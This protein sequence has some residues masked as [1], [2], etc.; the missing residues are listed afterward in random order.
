MASPN[1]SNSSETQSVEH[2]VPAFAPKSV[3]VVGVTNTPGT[4]PHDI[5]VNILE[6]GFK[7]SLYP[8]APGKKEIAGV[9]AYK[10]VT[11]IE[12]EVDLGIIVFPSHC[13]HMALEQCGQKGVKAVIIISAGFR[14][15]G[16][17]G[18]EREQKVKDI[19]KKYGISIIGPNCLGVINT[20]PDVSLNASF[21]RKMPDHGHIGF[22]SQSG[23]L[24][25]AVLDYAR[26]K[27]IGFSKFVSFGNK[28]GLTELDLMRY[29]SEDDDTRV[30]L[31]YLE[32]MQYGR[33]LIDLARYITKEA[34]NPKPILAIK[35]GRT[36][37]GAAAAASHTGSL[38]GADVVCDSIFKQ[39]GII[40][41][42][43]IED[44]FH[45]ATMFAYQ[46]LPKSN[47]IAIITN[48]GG[49][50]VMATDAIIDNHLE[51]AQF[52]PGTTEVLKES[53]PATAN[54]KNPVD[55][56]GDAREDRYA[57]ALNAV[58]KDPNVEQILTILTPQSMT[59]IEDIAQAICE[60]ADNNKKAKTLACSFMG[61]SDVNAGIQILVSHEIPHYALPEQAASSLSDAMAYKKWKD[62]PKPTVKSFEVDKKS[63]ADVIENAPEGYLTELQA[64]AVLKAYGLPILEPVLTHSAAEAA[65]ACN[66]L[67]YPIVMKIVSPDIIH[68]FDVGG[69]ILDLNNADEVHDAYESMLSGIK[70]KQPNAK[71]EGVMVR[72]MI[73]EGQEVILGL[74]RDP[75]Y[76]HVVMFGLGGIYVEVFKDVTFGLAPL[77]EASAKRMIRDINAIK[78][79]EG[80]RGKPACDIAAIEDSLCRISQL[81]CDFPQIAEMDINPMIVHDEGSGAHVADVR[82]RVG[83]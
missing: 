46:P 68:K 61:G 37:Q 13:V 59:N 16:P 35:S 45:S 26:A 36:A 51:L 24:C 1:L 15:V 78:I 17:K 30:I 63:A 73:P 47:K 79:L 20:D 52:E 2:I 58:I 28:A 70:E 11:D 14:E 55:V 9:K 3:A 75:V 56:I 32:E 25:T 12:D 42:R 64:S 53:L 33:E 82:I 83:K 62:Q 10:Y 74:N 22:L 71:I 7:G 69:V 5:F 81:A 50:G 41:V 27:K 6:S 57:A 21:A 18:V 80:V 43:T 40:R 34:P 54:I 60:I 65:A 19:A 38:A 76:G 77:D 44:M 49:P 31:M 23:A 72:R 48:A 4:V 29:M 66:G 39:A 8:V 67:G